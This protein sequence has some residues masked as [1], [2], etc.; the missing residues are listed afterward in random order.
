LVLRLIS[1]AGQDALVEASRLCQ[2]WA[3]NKL[4]PLPVSPNHHETAE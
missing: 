3:I 2:R 1:V 4:Q